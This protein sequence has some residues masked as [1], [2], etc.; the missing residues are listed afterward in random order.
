MHAKK[1]S[2]FTCC[3]GLL[4]AIVI[5]PIAIALV[6]GLAGIKLPTPTTPPQ[7]SAKQAITPSPQA[8][9]EAP[10]ETIA[11]IP[12]LMP[13]DVY[14]NL[15]N[16]GFT[17]EGPRTVG[18]STYWLCT[19]ATPELTYR[20]EIYAPKNASAVS[21]VSAS[22]TNSGTQDTAA[23]AAEFFAYVA[24]LPYDGAEPERAAQWVKANA[25]RNAKAT[26]GP[27][28]FEIF[29]NAPRAR[30]LRIAPN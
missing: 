5:T 11:T 3:L 10:A 18:D 16:K 4:C 21:S 15:T 2:P 25:G 1:S 19:S 22:L 29:A 26:F 24:T 8:N 14:L 6:V 28:T 30:I 12:E 9:A 23:L 27:V 13:V 17:K 7:A 20:V